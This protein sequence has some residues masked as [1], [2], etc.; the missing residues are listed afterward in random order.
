MLSP[1]HKYLAFR[2][3]A[4]DLVSIKTN[5]RIFA[6]RQYGIYPILRAFKKN[7]KKL[8]VMLA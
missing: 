1:H 8:R 5:D 7:W 2:Q 4:H 6:S 3:T